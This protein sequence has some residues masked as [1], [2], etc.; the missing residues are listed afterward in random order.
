M[1]NKCRLCSNN[2]SDFYQ[3][4]KPFKAN[5]YQCRIC[6][7]VEMDESSFLASEEEKKHY[8]LH[9]NDKKDP[10]Y[11]N[12]LNQCLEPT[13]EYIE[14]GMRG[15]DFGCG[16]FPMLVKIMEEKGFGMDY[17][18]P[19]FFPDTNKLQESYDFVTATEVVEHFN[20]PHSSWKKLVGRVRPGG[21]LSVMTSIRYP[22]TDFHLWH[23]R[24]DET[25]VCF[26]SPKT[27]DW[28][29]KEYG[30]SILKIKKN[31]YI[32]RKND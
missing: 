27:F 1:I 30:L 18:D 24:R 8:G 23:Y 26:Y 32:F 12:F 19:Y 29:A 10:G 17:F 20:N 25:H 5:Y 6:D 15:L 28:I 9:E 2:T 3:A 11:L 21:V 14:K 22:E 13:L 4:E 31:V 7:L 16:P